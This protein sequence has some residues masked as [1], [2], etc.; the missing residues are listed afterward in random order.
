MRLGVNIDHI[1]T[2]RQARK[3]IEPD[4][5]QAALIAQELGADQ[6]TAHIRIDRRHIQDQD[7]EQ[8][9]QSLKIP[10][11]I[12]MSTTDEMLE[13]ALKILP[14]K[15]TLVP[16]RKEEITTE[17]GLNVLGSKQ[18][19]LRFQQSTYNAGPELAVFVDPERIQIEAVAKLEIP[20]IEINTAKYAEAQ[21]PSEAEHER[22]RIED[23]A[24]FARELNLKVAAGHGL[25]VRNLPPILGIAAIEELN[26]GHHL[27]ADSIFMGWREKIKEVLE[28]IHNR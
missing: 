28:L 13:I 2:L 18:E 3:T 21:D 15:V 10:L 11:N 25:T 26:I 27:V 9:K 12:E 17:G 24:I 19:L 14:S 4:P 5:V 20:E 1:A 23:C 16:E 22:K 6:I 7:L 8:L